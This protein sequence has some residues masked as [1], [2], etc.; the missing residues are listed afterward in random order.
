MA[1]D[2]VYY[3]DRHTGAIPGA[4]FLDGIP[5]K[6]EAKIL[7]VLDAV[8]AA[9][10]PSFSGGGMWEAM[11]GDMTGYHEVRITGPQREHFRLFCLLEREGPG[12]EGPSIV[13]LDGRRK[14]F[15]TK[16]SG[17]DYAQVREFGEAYKAS[18]PRSVAE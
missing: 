13:V 8:A 16:L 1:W 17:S 5:D 3:Q 11:H 18:S 10:P 2:I 14:P 7:A 15:M 12:L 6:I 4:D 9:P